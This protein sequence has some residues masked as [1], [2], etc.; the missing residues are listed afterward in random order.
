MKGS[1][2]FI[3]TILMVIAAALSVLGQNAAYTPVRFDGRVGQIC[4]SNT[5]GY[6]IDVVLWHPDSRAIFARWTI[7]GGATTWLATS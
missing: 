5:S 4:I 2:S 6:P 3:L 7:Q 1:K